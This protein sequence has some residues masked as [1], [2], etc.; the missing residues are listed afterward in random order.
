MAIAKVYYHANGSVEVELYDR[1][2]DLQ[3]FPK[4]AS[5]HACSKLFN[6]LSELIS[7]T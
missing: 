3:N 1:I 6:G 5:L 4:H 7:I 2:M